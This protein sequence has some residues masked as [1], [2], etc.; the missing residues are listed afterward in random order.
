MDLVANFPK[1]D[2][3][4]EAVKTPQIKKSGDPI[5]SPDFIS[6]KLPFVNSK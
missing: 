6:Q 3:P 4:G 1:V 5:V 2:R